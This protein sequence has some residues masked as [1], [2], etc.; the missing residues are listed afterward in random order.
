[1]VLDPF[2]GGFYYRCS[3][4]LQRSKFIGIEI[5][6]EY[7]KMGLQRLDVASITSAKTGE[8]EKRKPATAKRS[9]LSEVTRISLQSKGSVAWFSDY[10]FR[11]Y[12]LPTG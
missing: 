2:A 6:S 11:V 3:S 12:F 7:I 10:S 1:M 9:R 4:R 8:S 5:N